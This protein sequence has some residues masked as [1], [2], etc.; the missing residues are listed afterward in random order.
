M[1]VLKCCF[2]EF[3]SL[4]NVIEMG[5]LYDY[6]GTASQASTKSTGMAAGLMYDVSERYK[7][8]EVTSRITV[9]INLAIR[10]S[11]VAK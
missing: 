8:I 1:P 3:D 10:I 5:S 4:H 11:Y 9:L 6:P 7:A 2:N